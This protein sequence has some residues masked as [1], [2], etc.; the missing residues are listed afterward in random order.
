VIKKTSAAATLNMVNTSSN[1]RLVSNHRSVPPGLTWPAVPDAGAVLFWPTDERA[2]KIAVCSGV[3]VFYVAYAGTYESFEAA[4]VA[5]FIVPPGL[6]LLEDNSVVLTTADEIKTFLS[7][8]LN[9]YREV[10]FHADVRIH[11]DLGPYYAKSDIAWQMTDGAGKP[12]MEFCATYITVGQA[13]ARKI[14]AI[15]RHDG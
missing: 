1:M 5:R 8:G 11:R 2:G 6:F 3:D 14:T 13:D 4:E 10:R 7:A 9:A 15:I 12:V